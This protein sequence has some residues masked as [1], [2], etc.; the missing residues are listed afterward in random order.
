ML[1]C[2]FLSNVRTRKLMFHFRDGLYNIYGVIVND[3]E[4]VEK[5][6][7]QKS[8]VALAVMFHVPN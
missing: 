3:T 8:K 6:V 1:Q 5:C 4:D 2:N 7:R